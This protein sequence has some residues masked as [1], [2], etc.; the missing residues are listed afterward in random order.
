MNKIR[1]GGGKGRSCYSKRSPSWVRGLEV[2]VKS[3]RFTGPARICLL[4]FAVLVYKYRTWDGLDNRTE[5]AEVS[6][7]VW[8]GL[9]EGSYGLYRCWKLGGS[10]CWIKI[11]EFPDLLFVAF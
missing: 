5:M 9:V 10:V 1:A 4:S 11:L 3:G 8:D 7:E 6:L 2:L